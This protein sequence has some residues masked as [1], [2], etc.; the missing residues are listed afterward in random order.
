MIKSATYCAISWPRTLK[1]LGSISAQ[2]LSG[3]VQDTA[4]TTKRV[5]RN[6]G[7]HP[8]QNAYNAS[9]HTMAAAAVVAAGHTLITSGNLGSVIRKCVDNICAEYNKENSGTL[10]KDGTK[11]FV[12]RTP[13]NM[14]GVDGGYITKDNFKT[15]WAEFDK[16][17]SEN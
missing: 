16:D 3:E 11:A 1:A 17:T 7:R 14:E 4:T 5:K 9:K 2:D 8:T 13:G 10:N 12:K 15:C 6:N